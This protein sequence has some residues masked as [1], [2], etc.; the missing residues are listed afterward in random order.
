[1]GAFVAF[2]LVVVVLDRGQRGGGPESAAVSEPPQAVS[3]TGAQLVSAREIFCAAHERFD[4]E[5]ASLNPGLNPC[6]DRGGSDQAG[7]CTREIELTGK[8]FGPLPDQIAARLKI[9]RAQAQQAIGWI[10][11]RIEAGKLA[12]C[13]TS[14]QN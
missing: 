14:I 8:Y 13:A 10:Q 1:M 6:F 9:P 11:A 4:A 5:R 3:F 7:D 12:D 2:V